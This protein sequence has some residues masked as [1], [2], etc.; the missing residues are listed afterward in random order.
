MHILE[1]KFE[2]ELMMI[3]IEMIIFTFYY[4]LN[5]AGS[6]VVELKNRK[7]KAILLLSEPLGKGH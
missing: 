3:I 5:K 1:R 2:T 6:T 4:F 7:H